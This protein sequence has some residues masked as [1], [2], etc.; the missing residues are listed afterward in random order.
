MSTF[1]QHQ[2]STESVAFFVSHGPLEAYEL[3]RAIGKILEEKLECRFESEALELSQHKKE[4]QT[5]VKPGKGHPSNYGALPD[6]RQEEWVSPKSSNKEA[7]YADQ[8]CLT[9]I[10]QNRDG[11]RHP[12]K[13]V[14]FEDQVLCQSQPSSL[15]SRELASHPSPTCVHQECQIPPAPLTPEDTVF[16]D[17]TLLFKQ[18]SLLQHFQ[19][20]EISPKNSFRH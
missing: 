16:R 20:E 12:S 14:A 2:D 5:Q 10:R 9:S 1:A 19:G 13:D 3:M 15:S 7:V 11:V 18:K 6:L 8:S 4:L 17:L